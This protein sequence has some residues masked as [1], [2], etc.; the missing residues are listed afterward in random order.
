MLKYLPLLLLLVSCVDF[1]QGET[2]RRNRPGKPGPEPII[3]IIRAEKNLGQTE[4]LGARALCN[5]LVKKSKIENFRTLHHGKRFLYNFTSDLC[6]R[7][8]RNLNPLTLKLTKSDARAEMKFVLD[9]GSR[10]FEG[11]YFSSLED[12]NG[13]LKMICNH[14]SGSAPNEVSD[15]VVLSGVV[16]QFKIE[17]VQTGVWIMKY[18]TG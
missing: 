14:I 12:S 1:L 7:G 9:Q 15:T 16:H 18:V 10:G 11:E 8:N 17:A 5:S 3:P 4:E 13:R 2:K 6:G